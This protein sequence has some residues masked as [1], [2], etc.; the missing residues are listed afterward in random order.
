MRRPLVLVLVAL[1]WSLPALGSKGDK[2]FPRPG[3]VE[4]RVRF[5]TRVYT[6]IGTDAGFLHDARNLDVVYGSLTFPSRSSWRSQ[7]RQIRRAK[8]HYAGILRRLAKGKRTNLTKEEGRVLALWPE[9]VSNSTLYRA[10]RRV[11]FQLGQANKFRA[12][13]VRARAW[14]PHIREVIA[15]HRVP[16]ELAALPHVESSYDPHAV[17]K[18]GAAGLWQFTRSTGRRFLRV[19]HVVDERFD[20]Y[21]SSE[22]AAELL[23]ENYAKTGSWPLAITAYNHGMN[24]VR[25]ASRK[26]GTEDIGVIIERYRSRTF[27]FASQNF[28]SEFLAALHVDLH[29]KRYFGRLDAEAPEAHEVV[30]LDGYYPTKA[31]SRAF[32]VKVAELRRLNPS[33]RSPVWSG[34]KRVPKGFELRLP[35]SADRAPPAVLLASVPA[36]QRFTRQLRD[37]T[38]RVRRGDTVSSIARRFGVRMSDIVALNGL[39][40]RHRIRMGQRLRLPDPGHKRTR[41]T[42]AARRPR[43]ARKLSKDGTYSVQRGDTLTDIAR[44]LDV[45]TQELVMANGLERPNRLQVGQVLRVASLRADE[46]DAGASASESGKPSAR[47]EG[48]VSQAAEP[49]KGAVQA[50]TPTAE[51][52]A[53]PE[54]SSLFNLARALVRPGP[55]NGP[56][57]AVTGPQAPQGE[58]MSEEPISAAPAAEAPPLQPPDASAPDRTPVAPPEAGTERSASAAAEPEPSSAAWVETMLADA[59]RYGVAGDQTLRVQPEETLGHYAHWLRVPSTLL[60]RMN[61]LRYGT[62]LGIG[63]RLRLDFSRV[64]P[65]EFQ[66]RRIAYHR[67]LREQ[68]FRHHRISG[69]EEHVLRRGETLWELSQ[70]RYG[71]PVWLMSD[72]NRDVDLAALKAGVRLTV[73]RVERRS[74][75][76]LPSART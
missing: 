19:D 20:P 36:D 40:N 45:S 15:H 70:Q 66:E 75:V 67:E 71:I 63:Q 34:Q 21:R 58:G 35:A 13:L 18:A 2:N 4:A 41:A 24:G 57:A 29:A 23:R 12:G 1:L 48:R 54:P 43:A 55:E 3:S 44:E 26:L 14:E 22:A 10:S 17:S 8:D 16:A 25:R 64:A 9:G 69:T 31:L 30:R 33:L 37:L 56:D 59:S 62:P 27:G 42:A 28:Y 60:R 47:A 68:F 76:P 38:Y 73:P 53:Q 6:E 50:E 74:Q 65:K 32:G 39:R 49:E 7:K 72:Y 61:R 5:W 52:E 51:V 46:E 11:R